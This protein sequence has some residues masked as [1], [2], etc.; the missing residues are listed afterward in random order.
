M[1]ASFTAMAPTSDELG[2]HQADVLGMLASRVGPTVTLAVH[3]LRALHKAGRLNVDAL[4]EHARP[5]MLSAKA[6]ATALLK[7]LQDGSGAGDPIARAGAIAEA[8]DHPHPDVRAHAQRALREMGRSDLLASAEA[9]AVSVAA[10]PEPAGRGAARTVT[11][12]PA[13]EVVERLGS[14]LAG[15]ADGLEFELALAALA[16]L[17]DRS[18]LTPL[19][20][21]ARRRIEPPDRPRHGPTAAM[22]LARLL[23]RLMNE[24]FVVEE[25]D[26]SERS[27][28]GARS[29]ELGTAL[30][31]AGPVGVLL[32]TPEDASGWVSPATFVNRILNRDR[33]GDGVLSTDLIAAL[34]RLSSTDRASALDRLPP[35]PT[36]A[37]N[38]IAFAAARYALGGEMQPIEPIEWWIAAARARNPL[39]DDELLVAAG[40]GEP[41]AGSRTAAKEEW[42]SIPPQFDKNGPGIPRLQITGGPMTRIHPLRPTCT[43]SSRRRYDFLEWRQGEQLFGELVCPADADVA[44]M[45]GLQTLLEGRENTTEFGQT[46]ILDGLSRHPGAWG[47]LSASALVIGMAQQP[48]LTR[49]HA[50]ELF[51]AAVPHRVPV[52]LVADALERHAPGCVITRWASTLR[53]ASSISTAARAAVAQTLAAFLPRLA[54]GSRGLDKLLDVLVETTDQ[55]SS[56]MADPGL[57]AWLASFKGSSRASKLARTLLAR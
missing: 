23:L 43:P 39:G 44:S 18:A 5:A 32:A 22:L 56:V 48:S 20:K 16:A 47:P 54:N 2:A 38:E 30:G 25:W 35:Q 6:N 1:A 17:E 40:H 31:A 3:S 11:P 29:K 4:A 33:A 50:A 13:D 53:D 52:K 51:A 46:D 9:E 57:R 14:L 19:M 37:T 26:T 49:I 15:N 10:A 55:G 21:T 27:V 34:L 45:L 36:T 42:V 41:G 7:I 28:V 24:E 8:L 12:W